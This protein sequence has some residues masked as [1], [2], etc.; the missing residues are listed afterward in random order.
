MND[1]TN[2]LIFVGGIDN[3]NV[4]RWIDNGKDL[5]R[6]YKQGYRVFDS[7]G[8][9]ATINSNGGGLGGCSG[10]YIVDDLYANR[11]PRVYEDYS[12]T[13]RSERFGLKVIEENEQIN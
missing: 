12:P 4:S 10:L 7:N 3:D 13:L 1:D 9:A 11:E 8:I 5:S 6:N 2:N